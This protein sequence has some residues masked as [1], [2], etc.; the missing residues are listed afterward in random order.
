M[1]AEIEVWGGA[2][3]QHLKLLTSLKTTTP[4]KKDLV[5][6]ISLECKIKTAEDISCIKLAIKPLQKVPGWHPAKG[7]PAWVF[8]DELFLN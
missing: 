2:D 4:Q 7:K 8:T 3:E 5:A 6:S 1:P